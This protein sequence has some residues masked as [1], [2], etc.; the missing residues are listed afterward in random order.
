MKVTE[1]FLL[2]WC[3]HPNTRPHY[4]SCPSVRP[5]VCLSC[6]DSELKNKKAQKSQT[7]CERCRSM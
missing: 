2:R 6:M 7:W 1:P 3:S 4:G 5:S